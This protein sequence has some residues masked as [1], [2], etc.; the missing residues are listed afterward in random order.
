MME[1]YGM[2][3]KYAMR[4]SCKGRSKLFTWKPQTKSFGRMKNSICKRA[5]AEEAEAGEEEE[6]ENEGEM[7]RIRMGRGGGSCTIRR[8]LQFHTFI[9]YIIYVKN[10]R[11]DYMK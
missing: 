3:K 4:F 8:V 6:R 5:E 1:I 11:A 10:F 7:R 9:L 2:S